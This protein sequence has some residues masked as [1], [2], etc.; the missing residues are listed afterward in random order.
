MKYLLKVFLLSVFV[1]SFLIPRGVS[2]GDYV[3]DAIEALQHSNVY[4][5][6]GTPGTN[7]ETSDQLK[8]FLGSSDNIV[9]IMLPPD[10]LTGTDLTSIAQKI[11][12][13]LDDR[14]T[15]GLAVG[16][17]VI[18]FSPILPTGIASDKMSRAKSVSNDP[19]TALIT[20]TQNVHLWL[21]DN[22]QPIP[23]ATPEPTPTPRPTMVPIVLPKTNEVPLPF[24][25]VFVIGFFIIIAILAVQI[26]KARDKSKYDS[27]MSQI[28]KDN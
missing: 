17:D 7:S 4:V 26:K 3:S 21:V 11:S 20:F 1:L 23:T 27:L 25:G 19:I 5:A 22:P 12:A 13:G 14:K 6:P 15:I 10:A 8:T 9:L 28:N 24:W 18:G 16:R 2:A